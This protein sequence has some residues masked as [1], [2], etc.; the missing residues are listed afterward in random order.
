MDNV[1]IRTAGTIGILKKMKE[2]AIVNRT[3]AAEILRIHAQEL[4]DKSE[5]YQELKV[6]EALGFAIAFLEGMKEEREYASFAWNKR[7]E[8]YEMVGR[9]VLNEL[10]CRNRFQEQVDKKWIGDWIDGQD[11]KIMMRV[12]SSDYGKWE[13]LGEGGKNGN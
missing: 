8:K 7:T 4:Q 10:L 5:S 1:K 9:P 11:S 12:I 3:E 6:M 13:E 2:A